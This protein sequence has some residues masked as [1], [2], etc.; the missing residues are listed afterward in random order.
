MTIATKP[1][2]TTD[3]R[4]THLSLGGSSF[5]NMG[6]VV[7]AAQVAAVIEHAWA[8]GIRYFDTAPHYG[9]GLS[10]Q[11]IGKILRQKSRDDYVLSSKVGRVLFA[12][13]PMEEA[14]GFLQPLPNAVRY[15]YS[16]DGILE[17]FEGSCDRLGT[18]RIDIVFAHDIG[19]YTHGAEQNLH[20]MDDFLGSGVKALRDLK[21]AGRI[22]AFG[23]GVNEVQVCIDVMK[24]VPLDVILL[25]GRLTLLDREAEADL[26]GLCAQ[27][28][29][30]LVLG[31]ILN[32]GI[33]ATGPVP[34]ASFDYAPA[35]EHILQR[36]DL[37]QKQA[38][39]VGM[40]LVQAALQFA[41]RHPAACS[42][43]LGTGK[44]RS[45][46]RNLEIID[47]PLSPEALAFVTS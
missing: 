43:L 38:E 47:A 27:Q 9:R 40:T 10:E 25:A 29:T 14:D 7:D 1:V 19:A 6:Q 2:G 30:S 36:V 45:L 41:A 33:L 26:L 18:S 3:L 23:L 8:A 4:V 35:P 37:L 17:S 39:S 15:D 28:Q 22:G 24:Q 34:S 16:G 32:S 11:R 20:H 42:V 44:L 13:P 31:G 5:G 21:Q 12:G 46:K